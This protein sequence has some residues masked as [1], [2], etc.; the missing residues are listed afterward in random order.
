[1]WSRGLGESSVARFSYSVEL[2]EIQ[3]AT[4]FLRRVADT[5]QDAIRIFDS[6]KL[7]APM[8]APAKVGLAQAYMAQHNRT[9]A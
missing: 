5:L 2:G 1:V 3:N 7:A 9:A 6:P 8:I 4:W